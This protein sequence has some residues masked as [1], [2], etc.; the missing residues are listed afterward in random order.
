MKRKINCQMQENIMLI[1]N[2]V[3]ELETFFLPLQMILMRCIKNIATISVK[4]EEQQKGGKI[5]LVAVEKINF[6]I[7]KNGTNWYLHCS[8]YYVVLWRR[9]K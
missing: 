4:Y 3:N 2:L 5:T 8:H 1:Q 7:A 6:Q 9:K